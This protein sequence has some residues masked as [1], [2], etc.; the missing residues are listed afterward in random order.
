MD[1]I[2]QELK[3][4]FEV[5]ELETEKQKETV[6][7]TINPKNTFRWSGGT[8]KIIFDGKEI[9]PPDSFGLR[10]INYLLKHPDKEIHVN[11]LKQITANTEKGKQILLKKADG[12]EDD[13]ETDKS[14]G[15]NTKRE[16]GIG[17][18]DMVD[19]QFK[20][21]CKEQLKE[22]IEE[23]KDAEDRGC[24][25]EVGVI[26]R[27]I[28]AIKK[29]IEAS[30]DKWGLTRKFSDDTEKNRIAITNCITD[31]LDKIEEVHPSLREHLRAIETGKKCAYKPE[32]NIDW[33]L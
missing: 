7:M 23:K 14:N 6:E 25:S 31:A 16:K 20:K 3:D 18:G 32:T 13:Y 27:K 21:E 1:I 22:L 11:E 12:K 2:P 10:Y 4:Q 24:D 30:F 28:L 17:Y 5:I 19:K 26:E 8:W 15:E 33:N 29:Q 9:N